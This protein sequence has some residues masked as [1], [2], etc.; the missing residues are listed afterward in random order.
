MVHSAINSE[1]ENYNSP[2]FQ[3]NYVSGLGYSVSLL[4][5]IE[6]D[7]MLANLL[8][9]LFSATITRKACT[10]RA[11]FSFLHNTIR[12]LNTETNS[13]SSKNPNPNKTFAD[14]SNNIYFDSDLVV[15]FIDQYLEEVLNGNGKIDKRE[16]DRT[17]KTA[18]LKLLQSIP[19]SHISALGLS[20]AMKR[21][22][23]NFESFNECENSSLSDILEK[24]LNKQLNQFR[25]TVKLNLLKPEDNVV[26]PPLTLN[27][28]FELESRQT[29]SCH[30]DLEN[31]DELEDLRLHSVVAPCDENPDEYVVD[32]GFLLAFKSHRLNGDIVIINFGNN[33]DAINSEAFVARLAAPNSL[34]INSIRHYKENCLGVL[35]SEK[36]PALESRHVSHEENVDEIENCSYLALIDTAELV[37]KRWS[38]LG[39]HLKSADLKS[40]DTLFK[41]LEGDTGNIIHGSQLRSCGK[42]SPCQP[43]LSVSGRRGV[44]CA[45]IG[46]RRILVYDMEANEDDDEDDDEEEDDDDEDDDDE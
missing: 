5:S 43:F 7:A 44:G 2:E 35:M 20:A 33:N 16:D 13:N 9:Q 18:A 36:P 37:Y 42:S 1:N 46:R 32:G 29:K 34:F 41:I 40:N 24:I 28:V 30:S 15:E 19:Q 21:L 27:R 45:V 12:T 8:L 6:E 31:I 3:Y 4:S 11:Y 10:F 23:D 22:Q 26:S 14:A 39:I 38:N 17:T 25:D